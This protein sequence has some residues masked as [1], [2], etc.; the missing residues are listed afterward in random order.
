MSDKILSVCIPTYNR[1]EILNNSLK[2][3]RKELETVN[4]D[5]I[6]L[7]V[8]DNCST[9]NT[10]E[11]VQK[12]IHL[13]MPILYIKNSKNLGMDGNFVQCFKKASAQYV[14]VLGDDDFLKEGALSLL[15]TQLRNSNYG[16]IHL[17]VFSEENKL[18]QEYNT[19]ETFLRDISYWITFISSNIV[20]T[21]FVSSIDFEKYMGSYF[22]LIPLYITAAKKSSKNL[23]IHKRLFEDAADSETNGGYNF[24][25]VFVVNYFSIRRELL[26]DTKDEEY[27]FK[28]EKKNL[29]NNFLLGFIYKL[30]FKKEKGRFKTDGG[31]RILFKYYGAHLYFYKGIF[32]LFVKK[33]IGRE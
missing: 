29:F 2:S 33:I 20:A 18:M 6:E 24:F 7:I 28:K 14:W 27:Y 4:C 31:L 19:I 21:K 17:K 12:Y 11:V 23:M 10:E 16:L 22:T 32:K 3:I 8:S 15:L 1:G 26:S 25:E 9:D 30:Y 13:G 5:E